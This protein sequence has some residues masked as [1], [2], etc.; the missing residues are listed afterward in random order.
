MIT[1][2]VTDLVVLLLGLALGWLVALAVR[3]FKIAGR[4]CRFCNG[5]GYFGSGAEEGAVLDQVHQESSR[6]RP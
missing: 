4:Q 3:R 1:L 2:R 5:R 6:F